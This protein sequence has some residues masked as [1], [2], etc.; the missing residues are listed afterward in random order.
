MKV[1][2][3]LLGF[4]IAFISMQ[5]IF[6]HK[7]EGTKCYR[8]L[9]LKEYERGA[10]DPKDYYE[11]EKALN[12]R[13]IKLNKAVVSKKTTA[14][15]VAKALYK[16]HRRHKNDNVH[17]VYVNSLAKHIWKISM[18]GTDSVVVYIQKTDGQI[19]RYLKYEL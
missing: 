9:S 5:Y 6:D 15:Y 12:D 8:V 2:T 18:V 7:H 17:K 13:K 3:F 16:S 1:V 19:L 10:Y 4:V 14:I 11:S